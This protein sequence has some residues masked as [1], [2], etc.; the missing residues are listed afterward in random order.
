MVSCDNIIENVSISLTNLCSNS[1]TDWF[2]GVSGS[3][4][5]YSMSYSKPLVK[6]RLYFFKATTKYTTTNKT[7]ESCFIYAQGGSVSVAGPNWR[8]M[9][10]VAG[11]EMVLYGY[12][13]A[14]TKGLNSS[15]NIYYGPSGGLD[16]VVGYAKNVIVYDITELYTLLKSKGVVGNEAGMSEWCNS[17]LEYCLPG[18]S[19][20]INSILVAND[21]LETNGVI[22]TKGNIIGNIVECDGMEYYTCRDE[23]RGMTY[24]DNGITPIAMVYN[25]KNNGSVTL[26]RVSGKDVQS[27]FYPEHQYVLKIT[28]NGEAQPSCGGFYTLYTAIA[29]EIVVE[30]FVAKIPVGYKVNR[31]G[32][33]PS[34]SMTLEWISSQEGTG[35]WEEYTV[36]SKYNSTGTFSSDGHIYLSANSGYSTTSVTWYLAYVN[37][38]Y[39]KDNEELK[40]YTVLPHKDRIKD[41]KL[42]TREINTANLISNGI[43]TDSG[44]TLPDGLVFDDTDYAGNAKRCVV[45]NV[46]VK[47]FELF[48]DIKINPQTRYKLSYWIKCKND[49]SNFLTGV[50]PCTS[51]GT[52]LDH[53]KTHYVSGTKTTLTADLKPGD[54]QI[55]V[56]SNNAWVVKNYS[57]IGFRRWN[58]SYNYLGTFPTS[59]VTEGIVTGKNGSNIILLRNPYTG[60]TMTKGTYVVES[61]DGGTYPYPIQKTALPTDNTWKYVEGYFGGEGYN[62]QWDGATTGGQWL[63]LPND[64]EYI[65]IK[66]NMYANNS[67]LPIKFCDFRLE[68]AGVKNGDGCRNENKIQFIKHS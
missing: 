56:S 57:K 37:V 34:S 39:I 50:V 59:Q 2:V 31:A 26:T 46:G 51:G 63:A 62:G 7:P 15:G 36:V 61:Y 14:A 47:A 66:V 4:G 25:N 20:D 8:V 5:F 1:S 21:N 49:M 67:T 10:P 17:N 32:N 33:T 38:C 58:D 19:Y 64:T 43:L 6:G 13:Y 68:E 48:G 11:Q 3:Y 30:K 42:F 27:P 29:N 41:N 18:V 40:N 28:T 16:G 9:N 44:M 12:Q 55:Q 60:E 52:L 53:T 65:R 24:F 54:T 23:Y 22:L 45:Q 35:E